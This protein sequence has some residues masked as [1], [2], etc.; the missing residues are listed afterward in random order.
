MFKVLI[1][2]VGKLLSNVAGPVIAKLIK[3]P[4]TD[5][6]STL[7]SINSILPLLKTSSLV[8]VSR[9]TRI[10]PLTL[11]DSD[12]VGNPHLSSILSLKQSIFAGY[13]LQAFALTSRIGGVSVIGRLEPL[14][15]DRTA[16]IAFEDYKDKLPSFD[17]TE[18]PELV[19]DVGLET[20]SPDQ[21]AKVHTAYPY[22]PNG[23]GVP[24]SNP[25]SA[26]AKRN[27]PDSEF[28]YNT[29]LDLLDASNLVLGKMITVT[30]EENN[31]KLNVPIAIRLA[32]T[33]ISHDPMVG[34]LTLNA[35][36]YS[37]KE[38]WLQYKHGGISFW[39]DLIFCNDIIDDY[40]KALKADT[41]GIYLKLSQRH[42][43][44]KQRNIT[45]GKVSL[46]NASSLVVVSK[47]TIDLV[48]SKLG[49]SFKSYNQ[50]QKIFEGSYLMIISVVDRKW[51]TLTIYTRN[52]KDTTTISLNDLSNIEKKGGPD[53]GDI[54]T[55]FRAGTSA[56]L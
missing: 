38:R 5:T 52:I 34:I 55:A 6:Q 12:L 7:D 17:V 49:M 31:S 20:T 53:I 43:K 23:N 33:Y 36:D 29:K 18:D 46:N 2:G 13:Y 27:N 22:P 35:Q 4:P 28:D 45:S 25:N 8:D 40:K 16:G 10:E 47:E 24:N 50:R 11:I 51:N 30:I 3:S 21:Q 15:V 56:T 26:P 14:S 54:L 41:T 39:N 48:E 42:R 44:N 9:I 19:E 1:N 37:F 32:C